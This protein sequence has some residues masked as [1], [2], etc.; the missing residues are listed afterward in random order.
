LKPFAARWQWPLRQ[1]AYV[2][3]L[4]QYLTLLAGQATAV[5]VDLEAAETPLLQ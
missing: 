1:S 4:R 5:G 3:A 2:T